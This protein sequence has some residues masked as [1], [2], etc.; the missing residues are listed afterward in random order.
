MGLF[1]EGRTPPECPQDVWGNYQ[2]HLGIKMKMLQTRERCLEYCNS[3]PMVD[4]LPNGRTYHWLKLCDPINAEQAEFT[5]YVHR[6]EDQLKEKEAELAPWRNL[7]LQYRQ[8][9][10]VKALHGQQPL[11]EGS[12]PFSGTLDPKMLQQLAA[13]GAAASENNGKKAKKRRKGKDDKSK[14]LF[15]RRSKQLESSEEEPTEETAKEE[16]GET[17]EDSSSGDKT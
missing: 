6:I 10:S 11:P 3:K 12:V 8:R 16:S 5:A 15:I 9:M 13:A 4:K 14:P 17:E 2:Y 7:I 1:W